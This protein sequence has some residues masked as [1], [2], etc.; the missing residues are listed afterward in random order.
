MRC[1]AVASSQ[2]LCMHNC[3]QTEHTLYIHEKS[4]GERLEIQNGSPSIPGFGNGVFRTFVLTVLWNTKKKFNFFLT[5][6]FSRCYNNWAELQQVTLLTRWKK[7]FRNVRVGEVVDF[8]VSSH[9]PVKKYIMH[10]FSSMHIRRIVTIFVNNAT[11]THRGFSILRCNF[12]P[13]LTGPQ[14]PSGMFFYWRIGD[15]DWLI[16]ASEMDR[17]RLLGTPKK[18]KDDKDSRSCTEACVV[19]GRKRQKGKRRER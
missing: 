12:F 1:N 18:T 11:N 17:R 16:D 13:A 10:L 6:I 19:R 8:F 7:L 14:V 9:A 4:G 15:K 3:W 2:Q 5:F